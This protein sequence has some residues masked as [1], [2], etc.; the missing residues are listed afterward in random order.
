MIMRGFVLVVEA[1][2]AIRQT[3]CDVFQLAGFCYYAVATVAQA[4]QVMCGM[5]PRLVLLDGQMDGA[6]EL[7][8]DAPW[9]V[10]YV[11][12]TRAFRTEWPRDLPS[13]VDTLQMP[14]HLDS[15]FEIVG[16]WL[17]PKHGDGDVGLA[18]A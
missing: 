16:R 12:M 4:R 18:L 5:A 14:F 3:L 1:D 10:R 17:T 7:I 13:T 6:L 2:P 9:A 11:L 15:L 8:C